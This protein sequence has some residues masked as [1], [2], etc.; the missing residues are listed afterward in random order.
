MSYVLGPNSIGCI[1]NGVGC[2]ARICA[3][4][5][6]HCPDAFS[7]PC[8]NSCGKIEEKRE[9]ALSLIVEPRCTQGAW[10][11]MYDSVVSLSNPRKDN[12]ISTV[13]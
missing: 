9:I 13:D 7:R 11:N 8:V 2:V 6:W 12:D 4:H 10:Y 1:W 5:P 3:Y